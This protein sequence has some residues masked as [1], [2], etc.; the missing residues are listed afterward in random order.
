MIGKQQA[1]LCLS[2]FKKNKIAGCTKTLPALV[3]RVSF[4]DTFFS[5]ALFF[6]KK[7]IIISYMHNGEQ[8]A[9]RIDV[10]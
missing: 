2:N 5:A 3:G 8:H 7:F 10:K 4:F 6:S 9:E 1:N